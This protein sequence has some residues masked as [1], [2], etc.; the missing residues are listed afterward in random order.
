MLTQEQLDKLQPLVRHPE[1]GALLKA[2]IT[3]WKKN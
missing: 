1:Y 2:A 3:S